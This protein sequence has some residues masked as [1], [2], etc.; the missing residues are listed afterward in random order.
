MTQGLDRVPQLREDMTRRIPMQ[1][2]GRPREQAEVIWFLGSP[3][4]SFVTGVTVPC[5]GGI[6]ANVGHFLPVPRQSSPSA[7]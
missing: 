1:R 4:A 3:A 6:S 5:D 2:W 7:T